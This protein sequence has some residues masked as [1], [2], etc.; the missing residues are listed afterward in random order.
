MCIRDSPKYYPGYIISIQV[1]VGDVWVGIVWACILIVVWLRGHIHAG[2]WCYEV[3]GSCEVQRVARCDFLLPCN[4]IK[5][6]VCVC[7]CLCVYVSVY[8]SVCVI[9]RRNSCVRNVM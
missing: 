3:V 7:V 4:L 8:V 6:C 2:E 9:G 1:C 5:T